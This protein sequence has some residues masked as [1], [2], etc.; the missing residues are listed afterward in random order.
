MAKHT[1][2]AGA[3]FTTVI[4]TANTA[5]NILNTVN[6]TV[7]MANNYVERQLDKQTTAGKIDLCRFTNDI[8]KSNAIEAARQEAEICKELG[9]TFDMGKAYD[10]LVEEFSAAIAA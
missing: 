9:R 5:S 1:A 4:N 6:N 8:V 2:A 10:A 3:L 7:S